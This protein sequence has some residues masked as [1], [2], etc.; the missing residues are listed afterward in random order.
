MEGKCFIVQFM[1]FIQDILV[2]QGILLYF[3]YM[4]FIVDVEVNNVNIMVFYINGDL[5]CI[6]FLEEVNI[7]ILIVIN[8]KVL[9]WY[10]LCFDVMFNYYL[11][12]GELEFVV[13]DSI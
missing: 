3:S 7:N 12:L 11:V 9:F 10:V 5:Y 2:I 6:D 8:I 13:I 1:L 4:L